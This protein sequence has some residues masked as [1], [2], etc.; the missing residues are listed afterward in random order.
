MQIVVIAEPEQFLNGLITLNFYDLVTIGARFDPE[1]GARALTMIESRLMFRPAVRWFVRW[2][3][4]WGN[5]GKII[6]RS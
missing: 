3:N 1:P 4:T 6:A 2:R 5:C